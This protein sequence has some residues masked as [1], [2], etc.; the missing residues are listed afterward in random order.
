MGSF[1]KLIER[2]KSIDKNLRFDE[3]KKILEAL[4]YKARQPN[5]G[6]SHWT[7]RKKG[8]DPITVPKYDPIKVCYVK[9]VKIAVE[10]YEEELEEE[11]KKQ[12]KNE[13]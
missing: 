10:K 5:S 6:S 9:K 3:L 7:F 4:G 13:D 12:D 8:H 2:I 11:K 1:D